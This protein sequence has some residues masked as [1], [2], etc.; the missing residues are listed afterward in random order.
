MVAWASGGKEPRGSG[1]RASAA[2]HA[3]P[4][5]PP[6]RP[7]THPARATSVATE[8]QLP[9]PSRGLARA[10]CYRLTGARHRGAPSGKRRIF[11]TWRTSLRAGRHAGRPAAAAAQA[12]AAGRL[13]RSAQQ[14]RRCALDGERRGHAAAGRH[15]GRCRATCRTPARVATKCAAAVAP[16]G[17][18]FAATARATVACSRSPIRPAAAR[19]AIA[20]RRS[21]EA[22]RAPQTE[23]GGWRRRVRRCG[24][25][26]LLAEADRE[27]GLRGRWGRVAAAEEA[28]EVEPR[29]KVGRV[30]LPTVGGQGGG[31]R[32]HRARSG[33]G[34]RG[35]RQGELAKVDERHLVP[36]PGIPA[37]PPSGIML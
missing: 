35:R 2:K 3:D 8:A 26:E 12:G 18:P 6:R 37:A 16:D 9:S 14:S 11:V 19:P 1:R 33:R 7:R 24:W 15:P 5:P 34:G 17:S 32:G 13:V 36:P 30:L 23:G 25:C 29:R 21:G 27:S 10:A 22:S 4:T 20:A 31:S 28:G